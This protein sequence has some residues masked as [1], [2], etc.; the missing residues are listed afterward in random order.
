MAKRKTSPA[1]IRGQSRR[2]AT[3]EAKIFNMIKYTFEDDERIAVND[4]FAGR[5]AICGAVDSGEYKKEIAK[6]V[7]EVVA[8]IAG[9][10]SQKKPKAAELAVIVRRSKLS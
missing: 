1:N 9:E 7:L 3:M 10:G 4:W 5:M 6:A 8:S 2:N